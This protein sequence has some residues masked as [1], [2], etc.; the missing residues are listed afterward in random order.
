MPTSGKDLD[1]KN[2]NSI[3]EAGDYLHI[4]IYLISRRVGLLAG[5]TCIPQFCG[6][7]RTFFTYLK[8][9]LAV[10]KIHILR[11]PNG[12]HVA[13]RNLTRFATCKLWS[14]EFQDYDS[15]QRLQSRR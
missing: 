2:V 15:H 14:R 4:W 11:R 10:T 6:R 7:V 9:G 8:D 5:N 12:I 1:C 3:G 13:K